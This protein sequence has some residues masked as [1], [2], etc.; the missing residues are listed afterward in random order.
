M[1]LVLVSCSQSP[2]TVERYMKAHGDCEKVEDHGWG[3][4]GCGKEDFYKNKFT[5]YKKGKSYEGIL[6]SGLFKGTTIRWD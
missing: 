4:F 6:C 1:L 5:C 2:E 3:F